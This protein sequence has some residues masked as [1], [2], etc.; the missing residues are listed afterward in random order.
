VND[1]KDD[2][3]RAD[4]APESNSQELF[5]E[6]FKQATMEIRI[7]KEGKAQS[8]KYTPVLAPGRW[9]Q[10][11]KVKGDDKGVFKPS[12][13]ASRK[14]DEVKDSLP[15]YELRTP[16]TPKPTRRSS[17]PTPLPRSMPNTDRKRVK[18]SVT[19]KAALL[20]LLLAMLAG[21]IMSYL[22]NLDIP[23]LQDYLKFGHEQVVAQ[24]PFPGK[25]TTI[26]PEKAIA[27][28][29][30]PQEKEQSLSKT[31]DEPK[32][33][34]LP[35][36]QASLSSGVKEDK[37]VELEKPSTVAQ[38]AS[39]MER[40]EEKLS[41]VTINDHPNVPEITAEQ[42][43][44]PSHVQ[45][46]LSKSNVPEPV[47]PKPSA[48][49]YPYSVYLGSFKAADAVKKAMSEYYEKGLSPY[50]AKV[51]LGDKGVWFRFFTGYFQ[52][53]EEA[54]KFIRDR[55]IQGASLGITKYANLIGIY[56]SDNEVEDIRKLLESAGFYPYVIRGPS[57]MSYLYSGAFDRKEYAEKERIILTSKGI[58]SKT[59]ER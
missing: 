30:Q 53:K 22:G 58:T 57:G 1:K 11:K 24:A 28:P 33:P 23:L 20:V 47:T 18:R 40:A 16:P 26:P 25:Q 8:Q 34:S 13:P 6:I 32:A 10:Q 3:E 27:S 39:G 5:E 52:T 49:K 37:F 35:P 59:T 12:E 44:K 21:I 9:Q 46:E 42:E 45:T 48:L 51:D 19:P 50:W 15:G 36:P 17:K 55:N 41:S 29:K 54:E 2:K 14:S 43:S 7:E 38:A 31:T 4:S 56:S